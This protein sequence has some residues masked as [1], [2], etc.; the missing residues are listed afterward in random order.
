MPNTAHATTRSDLMWAR[1]MF[2]AK[3]RHGDQ[4]TPGMRFAG[5]LMNH[6]A[7]MHDVEAT[8]LRKQAAADLGRAYLALGELCGAMG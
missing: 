3:R 7:Y 6:Y 2:Q 1:S 8:W 4:M 5:N